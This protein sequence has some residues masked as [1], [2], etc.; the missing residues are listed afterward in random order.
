MVG[1]SIPVLSG[2][3]W[4][5]MLAVVS[6]KGLKGPTRSVNQL[7]AIAGFWLPSVG[8]LIGLAGRPKMI[9]AIVPASIGTMFFWFATTLP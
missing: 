7:I 8:I 3:L 2:A 1:L 4:C 6:V 9:L 5:V